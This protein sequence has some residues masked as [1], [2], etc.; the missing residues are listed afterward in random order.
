MASDKIVELWWRAM[1][2][3]LGTEVTATNEDTGTLMRFGVIGRLDHGMVAL[4]NTHFLVS[5][6][7]VRARWRVFGEHLFMSKMH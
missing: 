5:A 2:Y 6:A 4:E 3:M 1:M 7:G